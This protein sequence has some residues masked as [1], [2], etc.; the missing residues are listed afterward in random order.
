MMVGSFGLNTCHLPRISRD[1]FVEVNPRI[2]VWEL[3]RCGALRDG[4]TTELRWGEH[5][6]CQLAARTPNLLDWRN[7]RAGGVG[8]AYAGRWSALL[9]SGHTPRFRRATVLPAV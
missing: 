7:L 4:P 2:D 6:G 5:G 8:R 1:C 3:H 9:A